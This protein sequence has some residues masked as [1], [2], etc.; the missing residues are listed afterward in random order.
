LQVS[1]NVASPPSGRRSD[2][3]HFKNIL[4]DEAHLKRYHDHLAQVRAE[5]ALRAEE[6]GEDG[7]GAAF[8]PGINGAEGK[9][10]AVQREFRTTA[11]GKQAVLAWNSVWEQ[12]AEHY[13]G[14][15]RTVKQAFY[16]VG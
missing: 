5:Q 6:Q 13:H 14:L 8:G 9:A 2:A 11:M 4:R 16:L 7:D 15:K 12:S 1:G 3:S 10:S